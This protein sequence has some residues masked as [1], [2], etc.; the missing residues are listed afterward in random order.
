MRSYLK[1]YQL[2]KNL[3]DSTLMS[4]EIMWWV[5]LQMLL[6]ATWMFH[7]MFYGLCECYLGTSVK[8]SLYLQGGN[9][10]CKQTWC[11]LRQSA[12][13]AALVRSD[14]LQDVG[15]AARCTSWSICSCSLT[16][17]HPEFNLWGAVPVRRRSL[18]FRTRVTTSSWVSGH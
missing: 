4:C 8:P 11:N 3:F 18:C 14:G 17:L 13:T 1:S 2:L 12:D 5:F 15:T 7:L 9:L 16:K 6:N 10:G